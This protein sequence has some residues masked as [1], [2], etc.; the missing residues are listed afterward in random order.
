MSWLKEWEGPEEPLSE[1]S[2]G[3]DSRREGEV[4]GPARLYIGLRGEV[5]AYSMEA[6]EERGRE[7][8]LLHDTLDLFHPDPSV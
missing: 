4:G 8:R 3:Q 5:S 2:G 6:I 7:G 1:I